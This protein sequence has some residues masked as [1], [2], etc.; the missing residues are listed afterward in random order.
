MV[1]PPESEEDEDNSNS[2]DVFHTPP[3]DSAAQSSNEVRPTVD[4][5]GC[6]LGR[7]SPDGG[8]ETVAIGIGS[9]DTNC[10]GGTVDLSRDSDLGFSEVQLTQRE[11][12]YLDLNRSPVQV[13]ETKSTRARVLTRELSLEDGLGESPLKKLKV[14][15]QNLEESDEELEPE[16]ASSANHSSD[17]NENLEND[18]EDAKSGEQSSAKR[19][20]EYTDDDDS[21]EVVELGT[22]P[23]YGVLNPRNGE[24]NGTNETNGE[25]SNGKEKTSSQEFVDT[26]RNNRTSATQETAAVEHEQLLPG[27]RMLPNSLL[28]WSGNAASGDSEEVTM[29]DVLRLSKEDCDDDIS[30]FSI[31][32]VCKRRG[33]TFPRPVWWPEEGTGFRDG[34]DL[35]TENFGRIRRRRVGRLMVRE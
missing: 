32:E 2:R 23:N 29:L 3:E 7:R 4:V 12:A 21:T 24:S 10:A 18:G 1:S 28:R 31:L 5:D 8:G 25:Q 6:D 15:V 26:V 30:S 34:D 33:M 22:E 13:L 16:R 9:S 11:N 35:G 19:K 20:L 14:S 17:S 27:R